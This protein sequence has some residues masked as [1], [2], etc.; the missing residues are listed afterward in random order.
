MNITNTIIYS[1]RIID[2]EL[3][4]IQNEYVLHD[5]CFMKNTFQFIS[6]ENNNFKY[7]SLKKWKIKVCNEI[8]QYQN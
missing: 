8:N 2:K 6:F 5:Y 4:V 7:K 1:K 3:T